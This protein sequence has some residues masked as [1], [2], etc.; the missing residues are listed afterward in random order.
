MGLNR[1]ELGGKHTALV[2]SLNHC[3]SPVSAKPD[4]T[5][6]ALWELALLLHTGWAQIPAI[7]PGSD[8]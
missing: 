6:G 2:M 5:Q 7:P 3:L 1:Q 8:G 4:R